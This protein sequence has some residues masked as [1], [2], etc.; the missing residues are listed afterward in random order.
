MKIMKITQQHRTENK[1]RNKNSFDRTNGLRLCEKSQR[2]ISIN[3]LLP[4]IHLWNGLWVRIN[5]IKYANVIYIL[6]L[7]AFKCNIPYSRTK[8]TIFYEAKPKNIKKNKIKSNRIK[9][10]SVSQ[11]SKIKLKWT[12]RAKQFMHPIHILIN[13][14]VWELR[15][16][17]KTK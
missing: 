9:K 5:R 4:H 11:K 10:C 15:P 7:T 2:Y 16:K 14:T 3:Y 8:H 12:E 13:D 1:W 17:N 6:T